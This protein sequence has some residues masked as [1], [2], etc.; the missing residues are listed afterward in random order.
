MGL[1]IGTLK[2]GWIMILPSTGE[3]APYVKLKG[4]LNKLCHVKWKS[5]FEHAQ[6]AQIQII[7]RMRKV[8]AVSL[9]SYHTL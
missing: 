2:K 7:M 6:I 8:S 1:H 4:T 5:A 9:L 3:N